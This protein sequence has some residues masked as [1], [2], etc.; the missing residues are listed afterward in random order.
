MECMTL[1]RS[2]GDVRTAMLDPVARNVSFSGS[3]Q[4]VDLIEWLV[5]ELD[6]PIAEAQV[7]SVRSY[8]LPGDD[9]ENSVKLFFLGHTAPGKPLQALATKVRV[10]TEARRLFTHNA[11]RI[12]AVRGTPQQLADAAQLIDASDE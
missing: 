2:I 5:K 1:I 10:V 8:T 6:K 7:R 12:I 4:Q 9:P 11:H 3:P